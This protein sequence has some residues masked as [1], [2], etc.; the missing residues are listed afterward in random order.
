MTHSARF[1]AHRA[2][3]HIGL[4]LLGAILGGPG[5]DPK[6]HEAPNATVSSGATARSPQSAGPSKSVE[7]VV[8]AASSL[9]R[10]FEALEAEFERAHPFADLVY[11]FAGTQ[12]LRTQIEQGAPADVLASAD[13]RYMT[14]LVQSGHVKSPVTFTTNQLVIAVAP[15]AKGKIQT[16]G[17]LALPCRL[18]LGAPEVPVGRY[19]EIALQK[20]ALSLGQDFPKRVLGHVISRELNVKQVLAKVQLGEADAGIVYQSDV[21]STSAGVSAVPIPAEFNVIASYPIAIT[22]H[23]SSKSLAEAFIALLSSPTGERALSSAGF[24][25]PMKVSEGAAPSVA[26]ASRSVSP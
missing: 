12:E 14:A 6:P 4:T 5:C 24:G 1:G 13:E 2:L 16:L 25:P 19:S 22:T 7:V 3:L 20:A 9:T 21:S 23:S 17:D 11:H 15:Q 10:P 26:G 18:V 8:F